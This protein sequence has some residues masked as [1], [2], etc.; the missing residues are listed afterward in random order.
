MG[1]SSSSVDLNIEHVQIRPLK[2]GERKPQMT[3]NPFLEVPLLVTTRFL[4]KKQL[5]AL[6]PLAY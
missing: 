1:H 2:A 3:K 4:N 5:Q 6:S